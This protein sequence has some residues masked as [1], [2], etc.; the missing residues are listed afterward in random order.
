MSIKST[1]IDILSKLGG[2][3]RLIESHDAEEARILAL[4]EAGRIGIADI[5]GRPVSHV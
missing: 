1:F 2:G 3:L 5:E 4:R